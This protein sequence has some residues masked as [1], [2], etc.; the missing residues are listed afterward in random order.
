MS[1]V[2]GIPADVE[3]GERGRE[4]VSH[5]FDVSPEVPARARELVRE[6]AVG[7]RLA[8]D[9][10]DDVLLVVTELVSNAVE[11]ARTTSVLR[12]RLSDGRVRVAVSDLSPAPPVLRP[13]DTA[14]ARGRGMQVVAA[15]SSRW[16]HEPTRTGK[17]VWAEVPVRVGFG[18]PASVTS[19]SSLRVSAT[20][21]EPR[22]L[23][24]RVAGEWD[25][26]AAPEMAQ[27]LD[28]DAVAD[29]DFVVVDL[30]GVTLLS[31]AGV[32]ALLAA[33]QRDGVAGGLHLSGVTVDS[34]P[35][36]LLELVGLDAVF[37]TYPDLDECLSA[38][39]RST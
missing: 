3:L 29:V 27:H 34:P 20:H 38:L 35:G 15:L 36:R 2:G 1:E 4:V 31:T 37:S 23:V 28:A 24:L 13:H 22:V 19:T 25:M 21:V 6:H 33:Y 10:V 16:H 18:P 8:P 12:L 30:T 39:R 11:H 9:S 26:G 14:A 7:W 32:S 5:R 17:T